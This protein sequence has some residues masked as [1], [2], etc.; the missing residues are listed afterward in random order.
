MT[1]LTDILFSQ[2]NLTLTI[3]LILLI[4]YWLLTMISGIEFEYDM[5]IDVD[6]DADLDIDL[7]QGG[8][9]TDFHDISNSEINKEDVIG[10]RIQPLK[11]W[12]ILLIYFNFIGL[13]FMFTFTCLIFLWWFSTVLATTLTGTYDNIFGF[14][15]VIIGFPIALFLTKIFTTPFKNFFRNLNKDGDQKKDY[16]G[17]TGIL[18][19]SLSGDKMGN[20]EIHIDGDTLSI[21]VKSLDG[22][23]IRYQEKILIIEESADKNYFFVQ[24]YND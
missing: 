23:P 3:L 7:S 17:R 16:I 24:P 18:L 4:V 10:K 13:P 22:A 6:V 12:Q 1:S 15:I 11:W 19:S 20:A 14:A 9:E 8:A 5:D 21:Y 2:V